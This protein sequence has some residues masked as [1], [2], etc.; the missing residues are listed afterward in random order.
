MPG[1]GDGF[2]VHV[3]SSGES[4]CCCTCYKDSEKDAFLP[5]VSNDQDGHQQSAEGYGVPDGVHDIQAIK[6]VL[7]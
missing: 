3:G 7:L 4:K 1:S 5:E 6:E 2:S